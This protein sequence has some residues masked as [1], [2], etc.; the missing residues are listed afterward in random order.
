MKEKSANKNNII[1][2]R[3]EMNLA[4]FPLAVLSTRV[5]P[6]VKTLE[7]Q[8]T[9]YSKDKKPITRKWIITGADKF[10]LPTSSDDEVLMGL[11]KL[12]ADRN[13]SSQKVEFTRYELLKILKWTT[14]GRSY[15]RLQKS[16]DRLSG[17]KIKAANAFY[18]NK[19]QENCTKLFGI[20]D[21]YE[22]N[23]SRGEQNQTSYFIWGET[24]FESF[25]RGN[26]KKI[27]LD[28]YLSL[29]SAI[30]KRLYRY[31]DKRFWY[32]NKIEIDL[33]RLAYEKIGISRNFKYASSLKQQIE[34]AIQE[35][36]EK[37]FI[38]KF[39][40]IGKGASTKV[41]FY[42]T[43]QAKVYLSNSASHNNG[44][45]N[46]S[47][48]VFSE[49]A[50]SVVL[51][52]DN[53]KYKNNFDDKKREVLLNELDNF[54]FNDSNGNI[55]DAKIIDVTP[56]DPYTQLLADISTRLLARGIQEQQIKKLL[57][58]KTTQSLIKISTII[59]YYDYLV[60]KKSTLISRSPV[61]WLYNAVLK[62][63]TFYISPKF[64]Q[65]VNN[66]SKE[67]KIVKK[68]KSIDKDK[69]EIQFFEE[70]NKQIKEIR[71]EVGDSVLLSLEEEA[72][73]SLSNIKKAISREN[74][75]K[76][77]LDH[78]NSKLASLF[79]LPNFDEWLK[80]LKAV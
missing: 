13:F 21:A 60:S 41:I 69:L 10:G 19:T 59:S 5:N 71:E 61:G 25:Q 34:P 17:V 31:L 43:G 8:D 80:E 30:S 15:Q 65:D 44:F 70:R 51:D 54:P 57:S 24:I 36:Q 53:K 7:F 28:F 55:S 29:K 26:I 27:D 32:G 50:S 3:D 22:I 76:A 40:F 1:T 18:D 12:T 75:E 48:E 58:N 78:V 56:E 23:S 62:E 33:F 42:K 66:N 77:V 6:N 9:I 4:E 39:E 74:F 45:N 46:A 73:K 14:E 79:A 2:S 64:S 49:N 11:L 20:I 35:L 63:E 68:Q 72:R 47:N 38:K 16:L 37:D 52:G 67:A